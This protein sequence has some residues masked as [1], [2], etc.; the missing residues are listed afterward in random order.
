MLTPDTHDSALIGVIALSK[1]AQRRTEEQ[2][3]SENEAFK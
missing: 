2:T 1:S 3:M